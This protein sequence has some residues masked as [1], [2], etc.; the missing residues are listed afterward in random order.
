MRVA[1]SAPPWAAQWKGGPTALTVDSTRGR[2][3]LHR[4]DRCTNATRPAWT[5]YERNCPPSNPDLPR[6]DP[7]DAYV[8]KLRITPKARNSSILPTWEALARPG[9]VMTS[10][11]GATP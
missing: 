4:P 3:L 6:P 2:R 8:T 11:M 1:N 5:P 9:E 7:L 10:T